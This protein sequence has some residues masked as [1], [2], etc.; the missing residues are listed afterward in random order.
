[1]QTKLELNFSSEILRE[2]EQLRESGIKQE[3]Y[4]HPQDN[5]T[6]VTEISGVLYRL[7]PPGMPKP[8]Y[9]L[10]TMIILK[11]VRLFNK[12]FKDEFVM[13]NYVDLINYILIFA[14]IHHKNMIAKQTDKGENK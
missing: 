8:L 7:T 10:T 6:A 9:S 2:V 4:G 11:L 3:H 1:M 14:D 5:Y 12:G 13:D